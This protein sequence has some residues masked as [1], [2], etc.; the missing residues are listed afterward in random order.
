LVMKKF[1]TSAIVLKNINYSDSHKIY[2]LLTRDHGKMSAIARGVRKISSKRAGNLDSLSYISVEIDERNEKS[3]SIVEAKTLNAF[4]NIKK[5]LDLSAKAFYVAELVDSFVEEGAEIE[6]IFTLTRKTLEAFDENPDYANT[7]VSAFEIN[8]L[9]L[10][11]LMY[12][13][14]RCVKCHTLDGV[15]GKPWEFV[16]ISDEPEGVV[17]PNCYSGGVKLDRRKLEGVRLIARLKVKQAA[18]L[19]GKENLVLI[20]KV[21]KK[22]LRNMV[23]AYGRKRGLKS[24]SLTG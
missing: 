13:F 5:S 1:N 7:V 2:T 21:L 23:S 4:Q 6:E 17:C 20:D 12:S 10:L 24:F 9:N 18:E 3:K 16:G 11:G 14:D 19:C 15:D 22:H 8:F